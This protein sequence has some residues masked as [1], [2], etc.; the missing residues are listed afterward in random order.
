MREFIHQVETGHYLD[1]SKALFSDLVEDWRKKHFPSLS[2]RTQQLYESNLKLRI[3]PAFSHMKV[4]SIKKVHIQNF[5]DDLKEG[6]N[7]LDGKDVALASSTIN[8]IHIVLGSLFSFA[9][10]REYIKDSPMKGI[11]KEKRT[12]KKLRIYQKDE[13]KELMMCLEKAPLMWRTLVHLAIMSGARAGELVG[14]EWKHVNYEKATIKIEQAL[15]TKTG[16]GIIVKSTKTENV[17]TISL[18]SGMMKLLKE[19]ELQQKKDRI[20]AAEFWVTE[21]K[22]EPRSFV[23][24]APNSL[25]RPIRPDSVSQWWER[26]LKKNTHIPYV[27]FHGLR[28]TSVSLL[29]DQKNTMKLISERVGHAKISTTMDIYGH[30]LEDAD[31][32]AAESLEKVFNE[33]G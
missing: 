33:L 28:H 6:R 24:S 19:Y 17:R 5:F 11:K 29:I 31:K 7:R 16:E 9:V 14:L 10:D 2:I 23:F 21:W 26:F 1:F 25:G 12:K 8:N 4:S 18:P 32:K 3:L 15:V 30:L 22:D 13:L 27:N 20:Q